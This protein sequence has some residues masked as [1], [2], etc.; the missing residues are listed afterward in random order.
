MGAQLIGDCGVCGRRTA[1]GEWLESG[2]R[3]RRSKRT[4]RD[5]FI[6]RRCQRE[7]R[8]ASLL[9]AALDRHAT[10]DAA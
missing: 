1:D 4:P 9:G 7:A 2:P 5:N 3:D 6:C 10:R 8:E